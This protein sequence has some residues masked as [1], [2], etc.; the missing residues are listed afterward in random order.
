[1]TRTPTTTPLLSV[2]SGRTRLPSLQ[3]M[4]FVAAGMVFFFHVIIEY[5]F[6]TP[7]VQQQYT[8]IFWQA[9]W[10]GV[11]FFFLLSGFV[12]TWARRAKDT[13]V[14]FWWRRL[15]KIYPNHLVTFVAAAILL[16]S[17]SGVAFDGRAAVLNL[18]LVQ[19]W[20]PSLPIWASFNGVAWSLSCEALF[21]LLF[22][23]LVL[24][25]DRI[26]PERLWLAAGAVI[27]CIFAVPG[28]SLLLPKQAPWPGMTVTPYQ[29]WFI[30]QLPP[31]RLLDFVLGI[32]VA[33][34][35]MTGRRVPLGLGG[36][37]A[38]VVTA[39]ALAGFFPYAY[40]LVAVMVVPLALLVAAGAVAD[41]RGQRN[42][43]SSR[44]M[45][46]LGGISFALYMWHSLVLTY[47]R[48]ALGTSRHWSVPV[49][50]GIVALL[51]GAAILVAWLQY[52]LVEQPIVRWSGRSRRRRRPVLRAVESAPDVDPPADGPAY[53]DRAA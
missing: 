18:L 25:I 16:G 15:V 3:G 41:L 6:A 44:P 17:V 43:L 38:L 45:V 50:M 27:A 31:T 4:R 22:P 14:G 10:T 2:V 33:R 12:L 19:A 35:V 32:L 1:M 39:Y 26:R 29:T 21:Y 47:G 24:V 40:T 53:R 51:F 34:I 23:F 5:V 9:G 20:S 48:E 46:W 7:R 36:A 49:A 42:V 11:G 13:T 37:I 28:L 30:Y 52:S 8:S